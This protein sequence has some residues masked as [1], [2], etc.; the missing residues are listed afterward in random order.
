MPFL[1]LSALVFTLCLALTGAACDSAESSVEDDGGE[2][3]APG[4]G[5]TGSGGTANGGTAGGAGK[6]GTSGSAGTGTPPAD[7]LP[8]LHV[9]GNRIKDP[10]GNDVILR[11]VSLI[12]LGVTELWEGGIRAMIDRLTKIDDTQGSSPGWYT[13]VVRLA[14]V[15]SDGESDSP[16]EYQA[17]SDAYYSTILRPAVDY[18][19]SKG[20]YVIIDWHYIEDTSLHRDTTNAFWADIAPRFAGDSHVM[21]E[22]YNEPING[23][24]WPSVKP[25]MQSFYDTVRS[26]APQN[27]VLVG[28]PNWSQVVGPAATDPIVGQNIVYVAHMYPLHWNNQSLRNQIVTAAAVH[29]V[30]ITEWG[31]QSGSNNI[32][33]GTISNYGTPFKQFL[34]DNELS[35]T[36]WC[37]SNNW[38]PP[39]FNTD[40]TLRVGEGEMGGFVKD[41]LYEKRD[42]N[43]PSEPT[44]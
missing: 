34:E 1:R 30:F 17:G 2:G 7:P 10:A 25:D 22:L 14:V 32:L 23:G 6:S 18:A 15:P 5:G 8:W 38:G 41:F 37:A 43:L 3:A 20:L 40:Y 13:R 16:I 29:P 21:F 9:E 28:T 24:S 26:G 19:L 39:I 12:D 33:N 42:S 11:G 44:N 4:S 27:L 35:W 31:F 36:A